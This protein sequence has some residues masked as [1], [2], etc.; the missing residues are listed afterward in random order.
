MGDLIPIAGILVTGV[1]LF[2]L[3]VGFAIRRLRGGT[4]EPT[5]VAQDQIARLETELQQTREELKQLAER[6][7]FLE[8]LLEKRSDQNKLPH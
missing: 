5:G 1:L 7:Q 3:V 2:P 8:A 4:R 6:Q